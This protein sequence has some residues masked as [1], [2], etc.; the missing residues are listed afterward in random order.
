MRRTKVP[1]AILLV[2]LGADCS[3]GGAAVDRNA[4]K[5]DA[6][7]GQGETA[8]GGANGTGGSTGDDS[9]AQG[10]FATGGAGGSAGASNANGGSNGSSRDSDARDGSSI[11]SGGAD[12]E[13]ADASDGGL[14]LY[15]LRKVLPLFTG[16]DVPVRGPMESPPTPRGWTAPATLPTRAGNGIGQH[17]MLYVGENYNR[18]V[19]VNNG[20]VIWTYDTTPGFELDDVWMLSNGNILYSHMTFAEEITPQKQVVWHYVPTNAEIH[21]LQPIG[22]DRVAFFENALP[23]GRVRIYNK[24]TSTFEVDRMVPVGTGSLHGETRRMRMTAAGTYLIAFLDGGRVVEYDK[25]FNIVWTYTTPRPW[26]AVRLKNGHTLI[27]D[28]SQ[29]T[30]KEVDSSGQVVWQLVKTDF[31]LPA[32]TM[33][34]NTQSCERLASGNTVMFGNGGTNVNNIQAVEVTPGKQVVWMLQDWI[35]LGDATSAQFLD[36]PGYPE[37]PGDTNH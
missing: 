10:G 23:M 20:N 25:N 7:T 29:S 1:S 27:Q 15:P 5:S 16:A 14:D 37:V 11:D 26:S 30:T 8:A 3:G 6:D 28:E 24:K 32:G 22:F 21:T 13:P 9:S 18:I 2:I 34:G 36:E 35:H 12:V 17:P 4:G 19:L 31:A 33:M